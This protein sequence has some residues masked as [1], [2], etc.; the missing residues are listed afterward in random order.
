VRDLGK[1]PH[2]GSRRLASIR[3]GPG[4]CPLRLREWW[5]VRGHRLSHVHVR[6]PPCRHALRAPLQR[7]CAA[8]QCPTAQASP[9]TRTPFAC[10]QCSGHGTQTNL[11]GAHLAAHHA[12]PC[13]SG[14]CHC[15]DNYAGPSCGYS[16]GPNG[17]SD[18]AT[19]NC[20]N[21]F[22]G[23]ACGYSCGSHGTSNGVACVCRD[24]Y[25]GTMCDRRCENNA[26][27]DGGTGCACTGEYVGEYC[28]LV[29][30]GSHGRSD[31][32]GS[33]VCRG[34]WYGVQCQHERLP[35]P[36]PPRYPP[37]CIG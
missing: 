9:L 3:C 32:S 11:A 34:R 30:C 31:G 14:A 28:Q 19:C 37:C 29:G 2:A 20:T 8:T 36:P 22:A 4:L 24:S 25:A 33:C 26:T 10:S 35:P 15:H 7:E 23:E 16:C 27:S 1:M 5:R 12:A 13:S 6:R 21:N 17:T 18:G